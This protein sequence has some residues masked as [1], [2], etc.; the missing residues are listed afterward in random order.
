MGEI[1]KGVSESGVDFWVKVKNKI[2]VLNWDDILSDKRVW[3]RWVKGEKRKSEVYG[4]AFLSLRGFG[5]GAKE[6]V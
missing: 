6:G 4:A 5:G 1:G 2:H 3:V